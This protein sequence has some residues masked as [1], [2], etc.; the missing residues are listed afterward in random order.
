MS[1]RSK[2]SPALVAS[3]TAATTLVLASLTA[4]VQAATT[5]DPSPGHSPGGTQVQTAVDGALAKLDP[6]LEAKVKKGDTA[7]VA[8]FA[9]VQGDTAPAQRV[10][11]DARVAKSGDTGLVM[12]SIPSRRCPSWPRQ[13]G[14]SR[15]SRSSWAR[16]ASH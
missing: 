8:V 7:K 13:P 11:D 10:L 2:Y 3:L 12:G 14:S 5:A 4:P 15:S 6:K 9:T 16:P 1:R